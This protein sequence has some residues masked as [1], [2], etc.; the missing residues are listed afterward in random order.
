MATPT[1]K[2]NSVSGADKL[3]DVKLEVQP[4]QNTV[5]TFLHNR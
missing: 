3:D 2:E 1:D 4:G 5:S